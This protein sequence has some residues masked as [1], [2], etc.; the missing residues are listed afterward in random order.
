MHDTLLQVKNL[1]TAF[2]LR[3]GWFH[4]VDDI[5]FSLRSNETL[6]LVGE[7]GCGKSV[8]AFTI[9]RLLPE[10][11][12]RVSGGQV[13]LE[14]K[15]LLGLSEAEMRNIRGNQ[16]AM[17]FQEPMTS[18]NPVLT[19]GRQVAE[20]LYYHRQL[21]WKAGRRKSVGTAQPGQ[22]PLSRQA[23]LTITHTSSAAACASA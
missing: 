4:A 14:G 9:M 5:S 8:T 1:T 21:S 15:D 13:L 17:I 23:G 3:K 7:S 16:L 10:V 2:K 6:A 12:C 22:D 20:T 18:L 19:I 11:G